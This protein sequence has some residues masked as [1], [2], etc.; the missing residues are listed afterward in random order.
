MRDQEMQFFLFK[1]DGNLQ[2]VLN[3]EKIGEEN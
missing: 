2:Q 3:I 1:K